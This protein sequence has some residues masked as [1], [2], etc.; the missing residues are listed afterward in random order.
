MSY[1]KDF[2]KKVFEIKKKDNLS[3]K[4]VARRFGISSRSIFRWRH[5]PDPCKKRGEP[6]TKIDME[7]LKEDINL[8]PD[9]YLEERASRLSVS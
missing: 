8:N 6:A 1:S 2:R 7:A 5:K 9:A 4:E 3:T